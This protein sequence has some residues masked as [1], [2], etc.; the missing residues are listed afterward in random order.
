[1]WVYSLYDVL[2]FWII[3][4]KSLY[5]YILLNTVKIRKSLIIQNFIHTLIK[6]EFTDFKIL[7]H[8]TL[9]PIMCSIFFSKKNYKNLILQSFP[10]LLSIRL[11]IFSKIPNKRSVSLFYAFVAILYCYNKKVKEQ[12]KGTRLFCKIRNIKLNKC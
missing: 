1:M 2:Y 10:I 11:F 8:S 3:N 9:M 7:F 4:L 5:A 12:T 6:I